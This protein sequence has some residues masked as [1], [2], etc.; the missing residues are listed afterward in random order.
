MKRLATALALSLFGGNAIAQDFS[1][2][3][4]WEGL[5]R[6]VTGRPNNVGNPVFTLSSVPA[7]TEW[8]YFKLTD[9]DVPHY[10][11]GGGWIAYEGNQTATGIFT[12]KSP[13][14]P[15]GAH[16]YKWEVTATGSRNRDDVVGI[17]SL[18]REYPE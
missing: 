4:D 2:S 1:V 9:L 11:H 6:C 12:Y 16:S 13:C 18:T 7:G 8:L 14:P 17:A 5:E 10:P 3:F 15:N